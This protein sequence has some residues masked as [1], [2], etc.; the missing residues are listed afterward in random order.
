M[1]WTY[2]HP[3]LR[4]RGLGHQTATATRIG[5]ALTFGVRHLRLETGRHNHRALRLYTAA[6]YEPTPP[7]FLAETRLSTGLST[8]ASSRMR[9][10][11]S[12]ARAPARRRG[13]TGRGVGGLPGGRRG[14]R[15]W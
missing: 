1:K 5:E 10:R 12:A 6:G 14:G 3:D 9:R 8:S 11:R 2:G 4:G 7:Y 15:G 13:R